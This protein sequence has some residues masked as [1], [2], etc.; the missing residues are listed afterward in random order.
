M[1]EIERQL[2][3]LSAWLIANDLDKQL[4]DDIGDPDDM[5]DA[6]A[7]MRGEPAA[8][9][10]TWGNPATP[11]QSLTREV[12]KHRSLVIFSPED[13]WTETALYAGPTQPDSGK[14]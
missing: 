7:A 1:N 8:W 4:P 10:Y 12:V 14:D 5:A 6:I 9:M 11:I 13:G 3:A 2:R